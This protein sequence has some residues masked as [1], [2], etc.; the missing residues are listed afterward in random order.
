MNYCSIIEGQYHFS[1]ISL[2]LDPIYQD[3]PC[4]EKTDKEILDTLQ[5]LTGFD[6]KVEDNNYVP[7]ITSIQKKLILPMKIEGGTTGM[8]TSIAGH[9]T[10]RSFVIYPKDSDFESDELDGGYYYR[11]LG[12][13][14]YKPLWLTDSE[15]RWLLFECRRGNYKTKIL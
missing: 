3:Y 12:L 11:K 9:D 7:L 10:V 15:F 6:W 8:H 14:Y 5:I 13:P 1:D 2:L 4:E